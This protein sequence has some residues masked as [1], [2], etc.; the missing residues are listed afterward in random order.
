M[1]PMTEQQMQL[2][3]SEV[4]RIAA[5]THLSSEQVRNPVIHEVHEVT[6]SCTQLISECYSSVPLYLKVLGAIPLGCTK[7]IQQPWNEKVAIIYTCSL[8]KPLVIDHEREHAAGK[9]HQYW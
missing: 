8:T 4:A 9:T 5:V 1:L 3:E 2:P 7:I 6:L